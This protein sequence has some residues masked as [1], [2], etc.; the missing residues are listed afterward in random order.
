ME[1]EQAYIPDD[2]E[3]RWK[4]LKEKQSKDEEKQQQEE[5]INKLLKQ[6]PKKIEEIVIIKQNFTKKNKDYF[7]KKKN[8]NRYTSYRTQ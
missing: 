8:T 6:D 2:F 5:K 1:V 7:I 4:K 3:E